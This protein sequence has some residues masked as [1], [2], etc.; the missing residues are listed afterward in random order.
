LRSGD[1]ERA[2]PIAIGGET[3]TPTIT[4]DFW[5]GHTVTWRLPLAA[6]VTAPSLNFEV[7]FSA[8]GFFSNTKTQLVAND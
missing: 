3:Y 7:D 2:A 5:N 6:F 8:I 1:V 4:G